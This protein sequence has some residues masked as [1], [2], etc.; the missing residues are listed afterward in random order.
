MNKRFWGCLLSI[1]FFWGTT[2]FAN[3]YEVSLSDIEMNAQGIF[4][5]CE[6]EDGR[7]LV[8][9]ESLVILG[10]EILA[11][12]LPRAL[13]STTAEHL[14]YEDHGYSVRVSKQFCAREGIQGIWFKNKYSGEEK[15]LI[16]KSKNTCE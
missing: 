5:E 10:Q 8:A 4:V 1:V 12:S 11:K 7:E 6:L 2:V 3:V 13:L 14:E 9:T 16:C 15:T